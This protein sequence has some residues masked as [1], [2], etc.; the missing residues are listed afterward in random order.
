MPVID[1]DQLDQLRRDDPHCL[2]LAWFAGAPLALVAASGE[3]GHAAMASWAAV[4]KAAPVLLRDGP[5]VSPEVLVRSAQAMLL[6]AERDT[7]VVAVVVAATGATTGLALVQARMMAS[8]IAGIA[9]AAA[10]GA[11]RAI[12]TNGASGATG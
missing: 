6:L 12:G 3:P 7:G 4:A 5:V 10:T 8:K 11:V 2:G 1:L 9:G